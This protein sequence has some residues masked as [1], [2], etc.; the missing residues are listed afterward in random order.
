MDDTTERFTVNVICPAAYVKA[1]R[2]IASDYQQDVEKVDD[3]Q[4]EKMLPIA[5]SPT[6]ENPPTHYMCSQAGMLDFQAKRMA[7][8]IADQED[9]CADREL[10]LKDD[11]TSKFCVCRSTIHDLFRVTGL[12]VIR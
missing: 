4:A 10:T 8:Y 1:A 5:L 3:W 7:W 6:G 9:W 2:Q 11:L 12:R